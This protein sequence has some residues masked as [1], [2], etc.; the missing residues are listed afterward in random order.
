MG[1]DLVKALHMMVKP[2]EAN[3]I[4]RQKYEVFDQ[5]YEQVLKTKTFFVDLVAGS[6][7]EMRNEIDRPLDLFLHVKETR[8]YFDEED[9]DGWPFLP[10]NFSQNLPS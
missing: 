3:R 7:E 6:C 9:E 4:A 8:D 2:L 1:Y 10:L 5:F